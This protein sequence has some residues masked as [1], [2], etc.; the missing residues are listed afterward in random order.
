MAA[1]VTPPTTAPTAAPRPPPNT[2]PVT[3]PRM[4]PPT[5]SCA[6]A[7][8][9][10]A[11]IAIDN[12]AATPNARYICF[13]LRTVESKFLHSGCGG[14]EADGWQVASAPKTIQPCLTGDEN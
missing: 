10:G 7:S 8:C 3:P 9:T 2:P 11:A 4:A 1:P 14:T 13:P 5:G 12:K 6:A